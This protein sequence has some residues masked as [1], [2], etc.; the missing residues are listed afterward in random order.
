MKSAALTSTCPVGTTIGVLS[1]R[2][3]SSI[4]CA[5]LDVGSVR[6]TELQRLT[7]RKAGRQIA[8]KVLIEELR[9]LGEVG[10]VR[11]TVG[12]SAKPPLETRYALS[13]WGREL[14]PVVDALLAWARSPAA[15][16]KG[17][18][19]AHAGRTSERPAEPMESRTS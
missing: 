4:L 19:S 13:E 18:L 8:R 14:Q 10:L 17:D 5:L 3:R 9:A 11:R 16:L 7:S 1:G 12:A 15:T 2:W 6:F